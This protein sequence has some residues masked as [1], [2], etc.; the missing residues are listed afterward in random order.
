MMFQ[1]KFTKAITIL[2]VGFSII[3]LW[4]YLILNFGSDDKLAIHLNGAVGYIISLQVV[5]FIDKKYKVKEV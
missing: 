1:N 3:A 2:F 4:A 5:K